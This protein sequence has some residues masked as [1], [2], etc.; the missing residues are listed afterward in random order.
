MGISRKELSLYETFQ[1]EMEFANG[2]YQVS[3]P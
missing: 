1:D 2:R 3:L